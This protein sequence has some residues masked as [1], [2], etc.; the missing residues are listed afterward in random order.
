MAR[1]L[2]LHSAEKTIVEIP[3]DGIL[4]C[5][6]DAVPSGDSGYAKG[7]ILINQDDGT[8]HSNTASN[9]SCTFTELT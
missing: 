6:A 4:F 7:C 5:Y 8:V 2:D 9:T 1:S 3:G